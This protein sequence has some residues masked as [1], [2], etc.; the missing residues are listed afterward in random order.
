[1]RNDNRERT[2]AIRGGRPEALAIVALGMA[3]TLAMIL[4]DYLVG[5]C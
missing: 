3:A 5:P 2:P 1:M 4:V